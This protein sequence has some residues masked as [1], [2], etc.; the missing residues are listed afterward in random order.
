M[1]EDFGQ[2]SEFFK[3][4]IAVPP[5]F[6]MPKT[7]Y[8]HVTLGGVCLNEKAQVIDRRGK[9]IPRLYAAGEFVGGI[10]GYERNGGCGI[11]ECIVF[12]RIAGEKAAKEKKNLAMD[13][14]TVN[15]DEQRR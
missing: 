3:R 10:H 14:P 6:A 5:F 1:D 11:T 13:I 8:I 15:R 7:Y 2:I 9:I 4:E 12:G